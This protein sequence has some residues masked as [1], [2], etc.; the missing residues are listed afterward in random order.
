MFEGVRVV[1]AVASEGL[2][3]VGAVASE[4]LRVVDTDPVGVNIVCAGL[5]MAVVDGFGRVSRVGYV[6]VVD[7]GSHPLGCVVAGDGQ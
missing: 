3:V 6:V 7:R 1:G 5:P 2:R 4:G